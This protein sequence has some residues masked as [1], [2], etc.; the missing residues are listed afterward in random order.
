MKVL[1]AEGNPG[2]L[3]YPHAIVF[4]VFNADQDFEPILMVVQPYSIAEIHVVCV[5]VC[6]ATAL[7]EGPQVVVILTE[8]HEADRAAGETTI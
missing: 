4:E 7:V 3:E 1:E 5:L 8:R 2:N 6:P